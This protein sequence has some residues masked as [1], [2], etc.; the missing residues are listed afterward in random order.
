M[1]LSYLF[2]SLLLLA[3]SAN[4]ET[5]AA[6]QKVVPVVKHR[7]ENQSIVSDGLVTIESTYK[8][9]ANPLKEVP[10]KGSGFLV[11]DGAK[12]FVVTASH[13]SQGDKLS[14]QHQG[15][16]LTVKGRLFIE[17]NDVEVMQVEGAPTS[18]PFVLNQKVIEWQGQQIGH[19][20][21]VDAWSFALLNDWVFDPNLAADN[22]WAK[23]ELFKIQCDM[24]CNLLQSTTLM[25]P[26]ASGSPLI[27]KIPNASEWTEARFPFD[28]RERLAQRDSDKYYLRG[29]TI[30]RDRFFARSSFI[31]VGTIVEALQMY[32]NGNRTAAT[33]RVKWN[34][35]GGLIF[36]IS[37]AYLYESAATSGSSGNGV[38]MDGGNLGDLQEENPSEV[39][40]H[41]SAA[42]VQDGEPRMYWL[43][44]MRHPNGAMISAP[45]WFDMEHYLPIKRFTMGLSPNPADKDNLL[46]FF[47]G[48]YGKKGFPPTLPTDDGTGRINYT[49]GSVQVDVPTDDGSR[50]NFY[51]NK[52]GAYCTD[53][54]T[55]ADKFIPIIEV[56]ASN[57]QVYFVDL[58]AFLFVNP[59]QSKSEAFFDPNLAKMSP[60]E[61]QNFYYDR[62]VDELQK[63]RL[64][65]R[66]KRNVNTPLTVQDGQVTERIWTIK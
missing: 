43:M 18:V 6:R 4:S 44:M 58:R 66:R 45:L 52:K 62:F 2:S 65:F 17:D 28:V 47:V 12:T 54:N 55:C 27:V 16:A 48:R 53:P 1:K 50:L 3:C 15:Q 41:I 19:A 25:Q 33:P 42:P 35:S 26:G 14:I 10:V 13:V 31:P 21:W 40:S 29:L 63:I 57:G 34:V 59:A 11:Q 46:N 23:Q 49:L 60:T 51:L 8:D 64:T 36:R 30:R 39:L 22:A 56:P 38:S 5:P 7:S 37:D 24:F 20:R 9:L 61:Y 32:N